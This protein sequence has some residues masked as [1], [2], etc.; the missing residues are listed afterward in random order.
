VLRPPQLDADRVVW[1]FGRRDGLIAEE[2]AAAATASRDAHPGD[3]AVLVVGSSFHASHRI[4]G[5]VAVGLARHCPV[6]LVIV[7]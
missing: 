3:I 1:K 5:S 6:P 2:L 4:I 7:P